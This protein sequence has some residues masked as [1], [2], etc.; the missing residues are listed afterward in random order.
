MACNHVRKILLKDF[1]SDDEFELISQ[2]ISARKHLNREGDPDRSRCGSITRCTFI[3][4]DS[5]ESHQRLILDYFA[6]S[7]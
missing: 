6:N 3:D 1:D 2:I 5:L 7:P 4:L